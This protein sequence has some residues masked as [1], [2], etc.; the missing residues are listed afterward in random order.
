M[1][2]LFAFQILCGLFSAFVASQ[3]GRNPALWGTIGACLPVFGVLLAVMVGDN[4]ADAPPRF[5]SRPAPKKRRTPPSRP[6]RCKGTYVPDC[7]GCAY[8]RR[9]LFDHEL[10]EKKGTCAFF[11]KELLEEA[12]RSDSTVATE[13]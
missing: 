11:G 5:W 12:D 10:P 9:P 13:K 4:D 8:F 3:K 6:K 2:Y 7:R 1:A